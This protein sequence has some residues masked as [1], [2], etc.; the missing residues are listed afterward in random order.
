MTK[1]FDTVQ[2]LVI[3][4]DEADQEAVRRNFELRGLPNPLHFA[5]N[6][7][8]GLSVLRKLLRTST[9]P[10]VVL[11]DWKMPQMGGLEFLRQLRNDPEIAATVVFVLT[12]SD[13][14]KDIIDAYGQHIAGYILKSNV[15]KAF[16]NVL[17]LF[18][19]YFRRVEFPRTHLQ[20]PP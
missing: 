11:L 13:D 17:R 3:E 12:S 2:V 10:C 7:A 6:G 9:D 18:D 20:A 8:L 15:G 4:D 5:D 19:E 16:D 1:N 14:E